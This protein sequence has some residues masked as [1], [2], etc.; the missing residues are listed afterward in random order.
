MATMTP[1]VGENTME[2][3]TKP[4]AP[5][6]IRAAD[7]SAAE[8]A[9][10]GT[11]V[12]GGSGATQ[13][14]PT[15]TSLLDFNFSQKLVTP[16]GYHLGPNGEG[17]RSSRSSLS[18]HRP[19]ASG[20]SSPRRDNPKTSGFAAGL[21]VPTPKTKPDYEVVTEYQGLKL[22]H[23]ND[24]VPYL[25]GP[26][27]IIDRIQVVLEHELHFNKTSSDETDTSQDIQQPAYTDRDKALMA[28]LTSL[29]TPEFVRIEKGDWYPQGLAA[30]NDALLLYKNTAK[31]GVRTVHVTLADYVNMAQSWLLS[32]NPT[33]LYGDS[34]NT[35][36]PWSQIAASLRA[37]DVDVSKIDLE[38][39]LSLTND[40]EGPVLTS[41]LD[42]IAQWAK[43]GTLDER[44]TAF[45]ASQTATQEARRGASPLTTDPNT[46]KPSSPTF[47]RP[48]ALY[49]KRFTHEYPL[50][51]SS[52]SPTHHHHHHHHHSRP[53]RRDKDAEQQA[54]ANA[55]RM[56]F[57]RGTNGRGAN[58]GALAE[59]QCEEKQ[60]LKKKRH[61]I[62]FVSCMVILIGG[63]VGAMLWAMGTR[64][65]DFTADAQ[66]G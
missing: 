59:A 16:A 57:S 29:R 64:R 56:W 50:G 15:P 62:V 17:W 33:N 66:T 47:G 31:S 10:I 2:R 5:A 9:D 61:K 3:S 52:T 51:R 42:E 22:G 30:R 21:G 11:T 14:S 43:D 41:K 63:A 18:R 45:K 19:D 13:P 1:L 4:V 25:L 26:R 40:L 58:R 65:W 35:K 54:V 8:S 48:D 6:H 49:S 55:E 37:R 24:A 39:Y 34:P 36:N 20:V 38:T 28:I 7:D 12:W 32:P 60:T 27:S 23:I 53:H 44:Y 46:S